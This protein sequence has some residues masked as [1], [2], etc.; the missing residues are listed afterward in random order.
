MP[1]P[2]PRRALGAS[3]LGALALGVLLAG[4][5]AAQDAP[6]ATYDPA[7]LAPYALR[8]TA[9]LAVMGQTIEMTN[10]RTVTREGDRWRIVD[11]T[12]LPEMAGGGT[13]AD[14]V[15]LAGATFG[16]VRRRMR[17]ETP[18]G[19]QALRL[20][21]T[22]STATGTMS[23]AG[24]SLPVAAS[25]DGPVLGG[26]GLDVAVAAMPLADGFAA[27]VQVFDPQLGAGARPFRL[28]VAGREALTVPAGTFNTLRVEV[29]PLDGN[30][31]GT[32]TLWIDAAAPHV[33]V[34]SEARLPDVMGGGTITTVLTGR[35]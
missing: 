5:A 26:G 8:A 28:R 4:P 21:F 10:A 1:R 32:M 22:D 6:P 11:V 35:D 15:E 23:G 9:T 18:M 7:R 30:P 13:V 3:A 14:T 29:A 12:H 31:T 16:P 17:A 34:K 2:S 25:F 20:D 33:T 19:A 27:A 24:Q